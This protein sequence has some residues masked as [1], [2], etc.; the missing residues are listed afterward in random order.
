MWIY[1]LLK[2]IKVMTNKKKLLMGGLLIVFLWALVFT[3][4]DFA[5]PDY[6]KCKAD[7]LKWEP[8]GMA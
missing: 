8:Q 4:S 5:N 7:G 6:I 3:F 2:Q 1:Y